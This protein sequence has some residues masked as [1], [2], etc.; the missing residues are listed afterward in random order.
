[1][2][3]GPS[4]AR[5]PRSSEA[6]GRGV[7]MVVGPLRSFLLGPRGSAVRPLL[8]LLPAP[9]LLVL[10]DDLVV[11]RLGGTCAWW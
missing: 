2:A 1:M 5:R 4:M 9:E 7:G 8:T 10:L 6:A 11:R 3:P